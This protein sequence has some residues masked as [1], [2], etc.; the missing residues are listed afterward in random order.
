MTKNNRADEEKKG[1]SKSPKATVCPKIQLKYTFKRERENLSI[2][3]C[4]EHWTRREKIGDES[5]ET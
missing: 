2:C 3:M 1:F 4:A 5:D